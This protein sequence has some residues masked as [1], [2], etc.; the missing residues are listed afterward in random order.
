MFDIGDIVFVTAKTPDGSTHI[1]YGDVGVVTKIYRDGDYE[2]HTKSSDYW[3]G[4]QQIR[5]ATEDE[6]KA[7]FIELIK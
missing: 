1:T 3:Y 2:V 6:I 5:L 7:A 4:E